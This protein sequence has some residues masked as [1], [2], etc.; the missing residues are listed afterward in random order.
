MKFRFGLRSKLLLLSSF[1]VVIP[2]FGYQYVWEM[3]KYLRFGQEQTIIGTARALATALHERP[4]LFNNQASFLPSVEKG[5]DLY[6]YQLNHP[7]N[8]DGS[9]QDWPNYL[10]KSHYYGVNNQVTNS[11]SKATLPL[12]KLSNNYT[13]A[14]GKYDKYLYFFV[15]VVDDK[16]IYRDKNAR[17]INL[18]DRLELAFTTP[19]G[20]F[21]RYLVAN[22]QAG[23]LDIFQIQN[24]DLTPPTPAL[25]IQGKWLE[26]T[27]GYNIE[28]RIP[29]KNISDNLAFAIHDVDE[30]FGQ[31]NS[32]IASANTA[33]KDSL[34][35][36]LV[37][38]PEI[39]R[40]VKGMSYTNS[41]V[42]VVD[43]HHR[44]LAKA[45]DIQQANGL[46]Q[47]NKIN[48]NQEDWRTELQSLLKPLFNRLLTQPPKA[49]IDQLYDAQNLTGKHIESALQGIPQSQW[50]LSSDNKAV[51]LTAA[52]P[53]Y[54]GNK[55]HGAVIVEETNNGI[56]TVR[57]QALEKLFTSILAIMLFGIMAFFFFATRISNRIRALR[58]Q[59]EQAID[60]HGRIN[61]V[62][63]ASTNNDEI[64]DL[65]RSFA[66]AVSRLSQYNHYL[67]N[68][69]SR[70]SHELRTP[71]AVVRTSLENLTLQKQQSSHSNAYIERAQQGLN[72]L[73]LILTNM[74]EA[75]RL[76][77]MLKNTDK[78]KFNFYQ[79]LNGCLQGYRQIYEN[80]QFLANFPDKNVMMVGSP[81]HIA[82]LLD[83]V[84]GN[85]VEFSEDKK[86]TLAV[87]DKSN[88]LILHISNNGRYLPEEMT[89]RLFDSMISIR[90]NHQDLD[91][92]SEE[93]KRPHL[94]LGLYIARLICQF[95]QGEIKANNHHNPKGVTITI[96]LPLVKT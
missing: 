74:S 21:Q 75:T 49:F 16:V 7:I 84:I 27:Q 9:H 96:T 81:E 39:E 29:L 52:Y 15:S 90:D 36:I 22:K 66:T 24:D 63:I 37:P 85:A 67:E 30:R 65:S 87:E 40:I 50:R 14:V 64:G 53:I 6:G 60:E 42:W 83:K 58:N 25:F 77:Q 78:T 89:E 95:H 59:A 61:E 19:E 28:F 1:L 80:Y 55:V 11:D 51:I 88:V 26:T 8:L 48:Q 5:K 33:N 43:Q 23:W 18:N 20:K 46:W 94:G 45:G 41:S 76:E 47:K 92:L 57:N 32:I 35:T 91:E 69:S 3:E 62:M 54:F 56:R 4:N 79:V 2:W 71:I 38:S 73:N 13:A 34:G 86:I 10:A 82:Q 70:L 93:N 12:E 31:T 72:R 68:M 17:S 44:V